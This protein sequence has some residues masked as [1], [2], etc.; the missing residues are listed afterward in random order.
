MEKQNKI[1]HSL[2][3]VSLIIN[4]YTV[5]SI[6]E[7]RE[8]TQNSKQYWE[9]VKD[10]I[11]EIE[12][13]L[14]TI[15]EEQQWISNADIKDGGIVDGKQILELSWIIND[16]ILGSEATLYYRKSDEE[17]FKQ[18]AIESKNTNSLK[19]VLAIDKEDQP[20]WSIEYDNEEYLEDKTGYIYNYYIT[21]N[22]G[23]RILTSD[24]KK[25]NVE[26][27]IKS[28]FYSDIEV[29]FDKNKIP[30]EIDLEVKG[31]KGG[32]IA[33][34][35]AFIELYNNNNIMEEELNLESPDEDYYGGTWENDNKS[36]DE[37]VIKIQ[38]E[39]GKEFQKEI[40]SKDN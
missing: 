17:D 2:L 40:W 14:E 26:K 32:K 31:V 9:Y 37:L 1:I 25:M 19:A 21:L 13:D 36:F 23:S 33:P 35:K 27:Y 38:Y 3:I 6:I 20:A 7:L 15:K 4:C 29:S 8:T 22:D 11:E 5:L 30:S 16:Y 18:I 10:N 39:D 24:I 34:K 12:D 28:Y